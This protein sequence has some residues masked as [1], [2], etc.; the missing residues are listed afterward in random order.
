MRTYKY[1]GVV[2]DKKL[3]W[4]AN[5][6][7]V[8]RKGQSHLIFLR[9]LRSFNVCSDMLW[10]F[11]HTHIDSA[12]FYAIVCW[13]SGTTDK[14]CRCLDKLVKMAI[15]VIGRELAPLRTVV[16]E[17]IRRKLMVNNKH[18]LHSILVGQRSI[19][20]L[21]S[22]LSYLICNHC[23]YFNWGI[24]Q[25]EFPPWGMNKVFSILFYSILFYSILIYETMV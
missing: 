12:L 3:E 16:E 6:D 25:F 15:S 24:G 1:L 19:L 18:T 20:L 23:K 7:T 5:T 10:M 8:Y 14:T 13:G 22:L 2:L 11:Y 17:R 21:L 4:S 9:R